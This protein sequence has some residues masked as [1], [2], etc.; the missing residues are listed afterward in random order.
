VNLAA[1][2]EEVAKPDQILINENMYRVVKDIV[3]AKVLEP[4]AI[5]GKSE[6]IRVY[7]VL[8]LK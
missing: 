3:K 7:E 1:R 5:A 4:M 2:L 8:G 6:L